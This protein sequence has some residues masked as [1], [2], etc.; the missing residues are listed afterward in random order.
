MLIARP[1]LMLATLATAIANSFSLSWAVESPRTVR[2][3]STAFEHTIQVSKAFG[4]QPNIDQLD[5]V[6]SF[7][8]R[9]NLSNEEKNA[10]FEYTV[11]LRQKIGIYLQSATLDVDSTVA[12]INQESA[13]IMDTQAKIIDRRSRAVKR[14]NVIN[15]VTGSIT[16]VA[17]KSL[18]LG[19][20]S[21]PDDVLDIFDG[22]VQGLLSTAS[23]KSARE[24]TTAM[25]LPAPMLAL[26]GNGCA[27]GFQYP[28]GV[29]WF[30]NE[31]I[32]ESEMLP[33]QKKS[34]FV[35]GKTRRERLIAKWTEDG[36]LERQNKV[37]KGM[38]CSMT[39]RVMQTKSFS[40]KLLEDRSAM[41]TDLQSV[42]LQI[43][44]DLGLIARLIKNDYAHDPPSPL[45]L[46]SPGAL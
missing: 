34:V 42:V 1:I 13:A 14:E 40:S 6:Q 19:S 4:I 37:T 35:H 23:I 7:A 29:W 43:K 15:F 9:E 21:I 5:K 33:C 39:S 10:A 3:S 17:G 2:S 36:F 41:L 32:P 27:A 25:D 18:G 16:K 45:K 28:E 26:L 22:G 20:F 44:E 38:P 46:D 8:K 24:N 31:R 12:Y 30:L 11:Y